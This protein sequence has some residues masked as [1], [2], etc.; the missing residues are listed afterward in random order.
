VKNALCDVLVVQTSALDEDRLFSTERTEA[1]VA[2]P[3]SPPGGP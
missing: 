2:S 3:S 1:A